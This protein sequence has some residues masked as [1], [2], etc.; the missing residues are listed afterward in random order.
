MGDTIANTVGELDVVAEAE[1]VRCV[2]LGWAADSSGCVEHVIDADLTTFGEVLECLG[3][4][5]ADEG[6]D[7]EE[8]LHLG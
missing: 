7:G 4:S 8:G 2:V 1:R 5:K 3:C 6:S